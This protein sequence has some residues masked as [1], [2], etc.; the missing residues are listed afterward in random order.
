MESINIIPNNIPS[1]GKIN[2]VGTIQIKIAISR[3]LL[4][5]FFTIVPVFAN[6]E[7][8]NKFLEKIIAI[9]P[10]AK[11]IESIEIKEYPISAKDIIKPSLKSKPKTN[12]TTP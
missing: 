2:N 5:I 6:F 1:S 8:E 7:C 12:A 4:D 3:F 9:F 10:D 11:P